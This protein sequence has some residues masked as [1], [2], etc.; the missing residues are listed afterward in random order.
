MIYGT[1]NSAESGEFTCA[2]KYPKR[3]TLHAPIFVH[4][5]FVCGASPLWHFYYVFTHETYSSSFRWVHPVFTGC[6]HRDI[7]VYILYRSITSFWHSTLYIYHLLPSYILGISIYIFVP[8]LHTHLSREMHASI[9]SV[10]DG[11]D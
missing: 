3:Y 6:T 10:T 8:Y 5:I 4:M 2:V 9:L 1:V 7:G 11:A